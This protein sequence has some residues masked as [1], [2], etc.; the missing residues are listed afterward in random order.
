[1]K[2]H[3]FFLSGKAIAI[4]SGALGASGALLFVAGVMVG[5]RVQ[6]AAP[7]T[8]AIPRVATTAPAGPAAPGALGPVAAAPPADASA[9]TTVAHAPAASA[10]PSAAWPFSESADVGAAPA[11]APAPAPSSSVGTRASVDPTPVAST[12]VISAVSYVH[13]SPAPTRPAHDTG[14]Y[15]VQVGSFRV[16]QHARDLAARL[17]AAGYHATITPRD[18]GGRTIHVVRI[19]RFAGANAAERIAAKVGEAEQLVAY[20]V[21]AA[22]QH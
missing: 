22:P 11:V 19:G 18:D 7:R 17:T 12:P 16:E 1:M 15:L 3:T 13:D 10:A 6:F 20:V 2:M 9:D 4:V 5:A 21:A 14:T 8:P